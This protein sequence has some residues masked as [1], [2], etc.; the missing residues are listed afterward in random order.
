MPPE[1]NWLLPSCRIGIPPH[2]LVRFEIYLFWFWDWPLIAEL[3]E[4][5][6]RQ[7]F[8][9]DVAYHVCALIEWLLGSKALLSRTIQ[10]SHGLL[11]EM[12]NYS[13][14]PLLLKFAQNCAGSFNVRLSILAHFEMPWERPG[15]DFAQSTWK[16]KIY[17]LVIL[18][19]AGRDRGQRLTTSIYRK[20]SRHSMDH[21]CT[22]YAE[23]NIPKSIE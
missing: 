18:I 23:D 17:K 14:I 10:L 4:E 5:V 21:F 15:L 16:Q 12:D 8:V 3:R 11:P 2:G 1:P 22:Y 6:R 9:C 13:P 7:S 19:S 20:D